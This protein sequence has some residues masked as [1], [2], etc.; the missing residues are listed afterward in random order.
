M[1]NALQY[2]VN[3]AV[4]LATFLFL[5]RFLLQ[6]CRA[7]FYNPISQGIVRFTDP[8]LK[9]ARMLI[10]GYRNLDFAAFLAA[11]LVQFAE[12][13]LLGY[14]FANAGLLFA[15]ALVSTFLLMLMFLRWSIIIAAIFSFLA[16]GSY[17]PAL[18]LLDQI[19]EPVLAPARR[20]LPPM[21]GL[22]LSPLIAIVVLVMLEMIIPDLFTRFLGLFM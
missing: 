10:P 14:G 5:A 17:H 6:A 9:P 2:L 19:T 11:V 22:D 3:V 16:P 4:S 18:R 13:L 21:G 7:D 15:R 8:V 1:A 12:P 20:I